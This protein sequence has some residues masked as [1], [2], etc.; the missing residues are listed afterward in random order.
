MQEVHRVIRRAGWWF[1]L[2]CYLRLLIV[3]LTLLAAVMA[4]AHIASR[5]FGFAVGWSRAWAFGAAISAV[6]ALAWTVVTRRRSLA[7]A[8]LVDDGAGLKESLSTALCV[9]GKDD[10]WSRAAIEH[11]RRVCGRV[12]VRQAIPLRAPRFWPAPFAVAGLFFLVGLIPQMDLLGFVKQAEA[13]QHEQLAVEQARKDV[14]A[15][16]QEVA[17][18]LSKLGEGQD[19]ESNEGKPELPRP[20][21]PDEIRREA[22]KRLTSAQDR[23]DELSKGEKSDMLGALKDKMRKLDPQPNSPLSSMTEALKR[24]DF[25]AAK[26]ALEDLQKK[27]E[28]GAAGEEEKKKIAEQMNKLASQLAELARDRKEL[29]KKLAES[30]LD[31]KLADNPEA[32]S[33]ALEEASH[34]TPEQKEALQRMAKA[35]AQASEACRKMGGACAGMAAAASKD[36]EQAGDGPGRQLGEQ[37]SELEMAQQQLDELQAAKGKLGEEM[38]KLGQSM[39]PGVQPG[40]IVPGPAQWTSEARPGA[41]AR[42]KQEAAFQTKKEKSR[43]KDAGGPIIGSTLVEGE[44]VKGEATQQ[45]TEAVAAGSKSAAEAI[46]SKQIPREYHEAIK[47]YFGRLKK[48]AAPAPAP[49]PEP[50]SPRAPAKPA[51]PARK[52]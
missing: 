21:T 25:D 39:K 8:R 44:Q 20:R 27:L 2:G 52:G 51:E 46:E 40:E 41:G 33:K 13:K 50:A 49:A 36:G 37:L 15:I 42:E 32:L 29:E 35:D 16:E 38:D 17:K 43:S 1:H 6:A 19:G 9:E 10:P 22:L 11:A 7:L 28:S 23:L 12:V 4:A 24:G 47:Q 48:K 31:P 26:E 18:T 5:L 34:L 3:A 45:F 14:E 30:G